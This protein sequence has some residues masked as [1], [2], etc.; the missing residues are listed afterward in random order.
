M[1]TK[2]KKICTEG[3]KWILLLVL[4]FLFLMPVVW[5]ICSSFKSVGELFSWP[6]SLLGKNPSLDNYTKAMAEGHFGIYFFNTVFVSLVA[7]FLT[8]VVN[9]MSGYAFA[10][11]HSRG[12]KSCLESSLQH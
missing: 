11:Y 9:V 7:T 12:T 1:Q 8:I 3:L 2:T 10:K 5:V 4:T 6:P